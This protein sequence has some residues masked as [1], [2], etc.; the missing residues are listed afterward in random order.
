MKH[1]AL[2][3]HAGVNEGCR[4][5]LHSDYHKPFDVVPNRDGFTL[6]TD[7]NAPGKC[8]APDECKIA[9]AIVRCIMDD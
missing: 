9:G 6:D 7:L 5:C 2:C 3:D 4:K 8:T 1:Y